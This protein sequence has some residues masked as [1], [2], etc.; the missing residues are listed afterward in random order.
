MDYPVLSI[1]SSNLTGF[2]NLATSFVVQK[3]CDDRDGSGTASANEI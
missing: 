3:N 1:N 2:G